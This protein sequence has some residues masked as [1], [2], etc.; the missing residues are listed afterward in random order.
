MGGFK[1]ANLRKTGYGITNFLYTHVN[2]YECINRWK[3]KKRRENCEYEYTHTIKMCDECITWTKKSANTILVSKNLKNNFTFFSRK[4]FSKF[5]SKITFKWVQTVKSTKSTV[6]VSNFRIT[7][8]VHYQTQT[9]ITIGLILSNFIVF[10]K[11]IYFLK[12]RWFNSRKNSLVR[13]EFY[14]LLLWIWFHDKT[15][16]KLAKTICISFLKIFRFVFVLEINAIYL[17]F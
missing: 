15:V 10:L 2:I 1:H 9:K 11:K 16:R 17:Y 3:K 8:T 14:H 6:I 5:L 4:F 7:R 12:V 13:F